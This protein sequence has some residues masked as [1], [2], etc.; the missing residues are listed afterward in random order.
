MNKEEFIK[1]AIE[2]H[3]GE[4]LD[5]SLVVYKS[6]RIKVKII[7]HDLD[8]NGIEYGIFEQTPCNHLRGQSHPKKRQKKI[9]S[10]KSMSQ[11]EVIRRFKLV[12]KGE[13]LD[14]SKVK[15]V[16]MHTPVCI[17]CHEKNP[18]GIEY[19][20]FW[21]EPNVHLKGCT[22]PKLARD[23]NNAKKTYTTEE[24]I[25][26]CKLIHGEDDYDYSMVDYKS[27]QIPV[28][29]ICKKRNKKG[30][31]HGIFKSNPDALLQGKGCPKCGNHLSY[32]EDDIFSMLK[33]SLGDNMIEQHNRTIL[34]TREID[35]YIPSLKI[36]IEYNG[37]RWHTEWLAHKGSQ[38]HVSK[39]DECNSKG[40]S[41]IQIFEDEYINNKNIVLD[42]I[43]HICKCNNN[44]NVIGGRKCRVTKINKVLAK[45]FL[46]ANHIQGFAGST[47]Y[48]GAFYG[49]KLL[50]VMSFKRCGDK[51]WELN[52]FATDITLSCPGIAGKILK[53]F[54]NE[55]D[56]LEIK[57]FADR[58]WTMNPENNLYTKI[59]FELQGITKPEYRYYK[60]GGE[61][62][63]L[64][65]FGFRKQILHKRYNLPLS[66]TET[67]MVQSLGYDRIW[68]CGLFK[69]V[70]HKK[71]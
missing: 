64:H 15:Y 69:Y 67:E 14:Y 36:G 45:D 60:I 26:K 25:Q 1:K 57:S 61:C 7:D 48:Y 37:L 28:E 3:P 20:E 22:H 68:D 51:K 27:S 46:N 19:G 2:T 42:K 31:Q 11:D 59:G 9:S 23:R 54:I 21:Q 39:T 71:Q 58:R 38:Y 8:E 65:K 35:I 4:N 34:K 5:Y 30:I 66:M 13:N 29:I 33:N 40:V 18:Q 70:W 56:P 17:I 55:Y 12:H 43:R 44:K 6:N 63:R 50:S 49:E 24:F 32:A 52:R 10:A 47:I 62:K 16:N 41:L 53:T